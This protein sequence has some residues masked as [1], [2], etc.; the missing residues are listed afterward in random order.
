MPDENNG[1]D[2]EDEE[3]EARFYGFDSRR[4]LAAAPH[5]RRLAFYVFHKGSF[6]Q[7][8]P[9][10]QG[11]L[12]SLRSHAA[13]LEVLAV[14]VVSP[15]PSPPSFPRLHTL[16]ASFYNRDSYP[17]EPLHAVFPALR[18]LTLGTPWCRYDGIVAWEA[19][20]SLTTLERL[21][22]VAGPPECALKLEGWL[23]TLL[24]CGALQRLRLCSVKGV[25]FAEL[26]ELSRAPQLRRIQVEGCTFDTELTPRALEV[27]LKA[28][29]GRE[30][31]FQA[32]A[33]ANHPH[34]SPCL[35]DDD[36]FH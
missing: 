28:C 2:S 24:A 25:S 1:D 19:V 30:R 27:A 26:L 11:S 34:L 8:R 23:N 29:A 13:D 3:A 22:V 16:H 35:L 4:L 6:M 7:L 36:A 9:A 20:A 10:V 32:I 14:H 5:L 33:R 15:A 21:C 17:G 18:V 31:A 12:G